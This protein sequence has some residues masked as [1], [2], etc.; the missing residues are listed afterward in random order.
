MTRRIDVDAE[1]LTRLDLVLRRAGRE[2]PRL[3]RIEV[4][5]GHDRPGHNDLATD[6][7]MTRARGRSLYGPEPADTFPESDRALLIRA[8][9]E[10]QRVA[11]SE[12]AAWWEGHDLP[13]SASMAY[14]VLNGARTLR[15][16]ETGELGSKAEGAAW[17]EQHDPDPDV[18]AL[19]AAALTYQRGAV[20]DQRDGRALD[21]FLDRVEA[22]LDAARA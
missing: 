13:E 9:R 12:G 18:H 1:V 16:L 8:F 19:L 11:R 10:D 3:S 6:F 15:Y 21:A 14:L 4:V 17:L 20:P 22:A 2:H 5:D 7:A